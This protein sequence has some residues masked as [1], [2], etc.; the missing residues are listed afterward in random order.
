MST[1]KDVAKLAGVSISTV[2]RTLNDDNSQL[3]KEETRR[4]IFEAANQLGYKHA[5]FRNWQDSWM[6]QDDSSRQ[7]GCFLSFTH[8]KY[9]HPYFS[10]ILSGIEKGLQNEGGS[11]AYAHTLED[12]QD[13]NKLKQIIQGTQV[14]G[15][16]II[17][18]MEPEAY[19]LIKDHIPNIV[20][21]DIA[22]PGVSTVT[23]DRFAAAKEA[24]NHLI[25]QGHER[26]GFIGG[27]LDSGQHMDQEKRFLGYKAALQDAGLPL[28][29]EWII[30]ADWNVDI[31]FQQMSKLL[32]DHQGNDLPTAM[33]TASDMM[34]IPAMRAVSEKGLKIPEDMAFMGHDNIDLSEYTI[35]PLSTMHV[36]KYEIGLIAAS[37][38]M[39]TLAERYP[40]PI[41][42]VAPYQVKVRSTSAR[43]VTHAKK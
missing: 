6:N 33:F 25:Q 19:R 28:R 3:V 10:T 36:P 27:A 35:P 39:D 29:S 17:E 20:G 31:S 38:M 7:I 40:L 42:I 16:I 30:D 24:V 37:L 11:L 14:D 18:D 15:V 43:A 32:E 13:P 8:D 4:K 41:K 2:S 1:L 23:Y 22:D 26:I 34:A 12:I 21:I 5:A 9:N